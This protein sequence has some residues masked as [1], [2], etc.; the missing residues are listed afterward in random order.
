MR[1]ILF[2]PKKFCK[3]LSKN[4]EKV[5]LKTEENWK[6][7]GMLELVK[8]AYTHTCAIAIDFSKINNTYVRSWRLN[9]PSPFFFLSRPSHQRS[10][11]RITRE[12]RHTRTHIRLQIHIT[13][14]A[15]KKNLS[16]LVAIAKNY[17]PR[18]SQSCFN[19]NYTNTARNILIYNI[20]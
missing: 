6:I 17:N 7:V 10:Q 18:I 14:V 13:V 4:A 15:Y 11:W 3:P 16:S 2:F 5:L 12:H 8:N 9:L 20:I 19:N 1:V